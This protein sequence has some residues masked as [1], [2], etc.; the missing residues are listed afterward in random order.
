[1]GACAE[2]AM[3]HSLNF[4]A[5]GRK[6]FKNGGAL[7]MC[8]FHVSLF[9]ITGGINQQFPG[10]VMPIVFRSTSMIPHATNFFQIL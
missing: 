2:G 10:I 8:V 9:M 7:K 4:K 3:M 1:M 5:S 6:K